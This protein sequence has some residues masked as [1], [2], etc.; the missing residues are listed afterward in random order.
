MLEKW[1]P[2]SSSTTKANAVTP[3]SFSY[4]A[5]SQIPEGQHGHFWGQGLLRLGLKPCPWSLA[6]NPQQLRAE[7]RDTWLGRTRSYSLSFPPSLFY[8]L[9]SPFSLHSYSLEMMHHPPGHCSGRNLLPVLSDPEMA[10]GCSLQPLTTSKMSS[11]VLPGPQQ[12]AF[13]KSRRKG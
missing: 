7:F 9:P 6:I 4:F 13:G 8:L 5:T 2:L 3:K 1:W 10:D 12:N 11:S